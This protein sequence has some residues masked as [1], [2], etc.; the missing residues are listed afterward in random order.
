MTYE[1]ELKWREME[2]LLPMLVKSLEKRKEIIKL[3]DSID[4]KR[5]FQGIVVDEELSKLKRM[6]YEVIEESQYFMKISKV[7][8]DI[9]IGR[10][11]IT[12]KETEGLLYLMWLTKLSVKDFFDVREYVPTV[13]TEKISKKYD[14]ISFY[15]ATFI[16]VFQIPRIT[17]IRI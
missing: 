8:K 16:D 17:P 9:K 14:G 7:V 4:E 10:K 6:K 11:Q 12:R 13:V 1:Q 5:H 15:N 3:E 2:R